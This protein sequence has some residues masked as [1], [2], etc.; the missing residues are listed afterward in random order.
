MLTLAGLLQ[1]VL[2]AAGDDLQLEGQIFINNMPQ[3]QDLRLLLIIH[4]RQHIDGEA[5]L[6]LGLGKEAI[7]DHLRIGIAL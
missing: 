4:Q 6:H 3:G 7:Q 2:S 5:G 1:I